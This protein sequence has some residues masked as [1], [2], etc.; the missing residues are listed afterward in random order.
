MVNN[1]KE[2]N[3]LRSRLREENATSYSNEGDID[4]RLDEQ[5]GL[6]GD[7]CIQY[8]ECIICRQVKYF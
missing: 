4:I 5:N 1:R 6:V 2:I 8:T 3:E 7:L